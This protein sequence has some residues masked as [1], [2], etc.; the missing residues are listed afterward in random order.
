MLARH[1]HLVV[2]I[3]LVTACGGGVDEGSGGDGSGGDATGSGDGTGGGTDS[4][5]ADGTD[6]TGGSDTGEGGGTGDGSTG[7]GPSDWDDL[8]DQV[9][10][11]DHIVEIR[12]DFAPGDWDAVLRDWDQ[13]RQKT[14]YP[15]AFR[16]D[17]ESLKEIGVRLKGWSS[18]RNGSGRGGGPSWGGSDPD[19]KFPLK[20][21]FDYYGG[22]RF[23]E[24]DRVNL[25]NNWADISFM[26]DRLAARMFNAMGVHSARTA[27]AKTWVD[28]MYLG[29]HTMIQ[30]VDKR[31]LKERFGEAAGADDGN[32]YKC[33]FTDE[34]T[35]G[36]GYRGPDK[37]SYIHT[38]SCPESYDECGLVLKTNVDDPAKNDY[39]DIVHFL[40]VLNNTSDAEFPAAIDAVFD[41]DNFLRLTAVNVAL[42]NVDSYF[43]MAHNYYLYHHPVTDK[44]VMIPWDLNEAYAGHPC[45]DQ[46][47]TLSIHD[48]VCNQRE[49]G[50]P[51][52]ER[53]LA[54]PELK[55]RYLDY[56][57]EVVDSWLTFDVQSKWIGEYDGLIG[58]QIGSDPNYITTVE[59]Y[60]IAISDQP[61]GGPNLGG[62]GGFE[63]NLLDFVL[64]RR[65]AIL[66]EL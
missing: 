30:Q 59:N 27:Y 24:V 28:D 9:F 37:S 56:V 3:C 7:G 53:I 10:P 65:E 54:V 8:F 48:P 44:F 62:H 19:G 35:C 50:L 52:V 41:V 38:T 51:L 63:Y 40:D 18:L 31:F 45:G 4:G 57:R 12:L 43:G 26:R 32:L 64:K 29:I 42:S 5:G 16:F 46:L 39:A 22:P 61:S 15:A 60:R 23:H 25:A 13:L 2:T 47:H 49:F 58:D 17:D 20:L 1:A 66:A 14:Y 55:Q 34:P 21:N 36:L 11:Q 33:V 6:A